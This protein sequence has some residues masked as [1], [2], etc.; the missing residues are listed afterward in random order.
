M[1]KE[2]MIEMIK[3]VKS[4]IREKQTLYKVADELGITY[5]KNNCPR[6]AK[7][8]W[9]IIREEL[10]LIKDAAD[11][12][13][14]NNTGEWVYLLKKPQSWHGHIID[15][16]TD[17]DIIAQFVKDHPKG[18]YKKIEKTEPQHEEQIN[19]ED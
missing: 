6:C 8:L 1:T 14:F 17:P 4:P 10:G 5:K 16:D 15:Q 19:N 9:N 2:E 3:I 7:D 13:D 18:Y 12:S 11:E